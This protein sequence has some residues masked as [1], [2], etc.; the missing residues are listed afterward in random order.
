MKQKVNI[1]ILS[2]LLSISYLTVSAQEGIIK[3]TV[4]DIDGLEMVGVTVV[5]E[6]TQTGITTDLSGEFSL[7]GK[8]GDV[9]RFSFMGF[10]TESITYKKSQPMKV[11]LKEDL[12]LLDDVIVVGYGT[13]K[14]KEVTGV[15]SNISMEDISEVQ[16]SESADNMLQGRIAGVNIQLN[17]GEPGAQPTV[18]IRGLAAVSREDGAAVSEPLYV[19][20]G[21]PII[22]RTSDEFAISSTN[23]IADIDPSDIADITVLKDASAAAIYGSR[24]ANGVIMITTK[25]GKTGRPQINFNL[26]YGV[27]FVPQLRDIA[28]GVKEREQVIQLYEQYAPYNTSL[29]VEY[30]DITN[31]FWNNSSDWQ[32]YYYN[33]SS[34]K[35]LNG[36]IRG[37][38]DFGQY[39]ISLGYTDNVGIQ[40]NSGFKRYNSNMNTTFNALGNKLIINSS[41]AI[42]RTDK[43]KNPD[44]ISSSYSSLLPL[45]SDP[46]VDGAMV[47][48]VGY[49]NDLNDKIRVSTDATVNIMN[50]LSYN[51]RLSY[52]Y[53]RS[54]G[55]SFSESRRTLSASNSSSLG[56]S[57]N[58]L[59]QNTL[60]YAPQF[61]N[62]DHTFNILVGQSAEKSE[63]ESSSVESIESTPTLSNTVNIP[64]SQSTGS[65]NY[66]AN[67]M[68]SLF[69]RVNYSYKEKYMVGA[70]L[71]TDGSS[72]F[73][74]N[75]KWGL[76]PSASAGWNIGDEPIIKNIGWIDMMK[77]RGSYGVS[78]TT[79]SDNYLALGLMDVGT[80][81]QYNSVIDISY[82]GI[83]GFTPEW[84]D[85]FR[86]DD[87]TWV[88][89]EMGNIG[90]DLTLLDGKIE[91]IFDAYEKLTKGLLLT[92]DL[93]TTS[94][95]NQ[96]YRNAADVM[97]RGLEFTFNTRTNITGML[98]WD[99][100][101]NFAY[102]KNRVVE[103]PDNNSD[104]IKVG[105]SGQDFGSVVRVG[106]PL[107]GFFFYESAGIYQSEADIPIDPETGKSL[108]GL[109]SKVLTVGDRSFV[110]Q[111]GDYEIDVDDRVYM[112]DPNP[113]WTGGW[114]NDFRIK[115]FSLSTVCS[116]VIGR[117][118]VNSD[119]LDRLSL[120][121][122]FAGSPLPDFDNYSIWEKP[123]DDAKFPTLDPWNG[124][125]QIITQDSEYVEDGSYFKVKSL[126]LSYNM[127]KNI[128]R[129]LSMTKGRVY[130]TIDNLV[131]LQNYSGSDAELV[132]TG[133]FDSSGGYPMRRMVLLG[134]SFGL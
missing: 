121:K 88:T 111:N 94:G 66:S 117:D 53:N 65:S 106:T 41:L 87:L 93:P 105:E 76:F 120:D 103:L 4:Y 18:I 56:E 44:A 69:T 52:E 97:N 128:A 73:G 91:F 101:L 109:Q 6:G 8:I 81:D 9:L 74:E 96:V 5:I 72:K 85:G 115:N 131:T 124:I 129:K 59:F 62:S 126:S 114:T 130:C 24:A 39:S 33:T 30:A 104:I 84:Y 31:P 58:L 86:N 95:Y 21:V 54:M 80:L 60:N 68:L 10:K 35:V 7:K 125:S 132:S 20:D 19:V 79:F 127:P 46:I 12:V 100:G 22:S 78:G 47:F 42:S 75:N 119:L 107:N 99:M 32:G 83:N 61:S 38:G 122:G 34:T 112:G 23:V 50:S 63:S 14:T 2:L 16:S 37:A 17:S 134:F 25:R 70:S 3:G 110:D 27:N 108:V 28:G 57:Q 15:I 51:V 1:A 36:S 90:F 123:G 98:S 89:S 49:Y 11:T 43:S 67:T 13:Q 29:P 102:N 116:F 55:D 82:G 113:A 64:Y 71:R 77:I 133:G 48:G 40:Y 45:P 92:T 26:R 118:I